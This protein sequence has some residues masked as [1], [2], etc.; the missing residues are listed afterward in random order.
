MQFAHSSQFF[1]VV[2][3]YTPEEIVVVLTSTQKVTLRLT[4]RRWLWWEDMDHFLMH[5]P[6]ASRL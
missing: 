4:S 5:C 2:T 6:A 1:L 3:H